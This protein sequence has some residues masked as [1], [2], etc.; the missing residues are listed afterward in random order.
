MQQSDKVSDTN[1]WLCSGWGNNELE[2][3]TDAVSN[4]KVT[5]LDGI[6]VLQITARKESANGVQPYTSAKLVTQGLQSFTPKSSAKGIRVAVRALMPEGVSIL[7]L[8]CSNS[9]VDMC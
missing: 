7:S 9:S 1:S 8:S 6:G 2:Y 5:T 4:A 3:Y